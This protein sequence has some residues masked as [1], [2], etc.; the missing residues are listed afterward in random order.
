MAYNRLDTAELKDKLDRVQKDIETR[1]QRL[2]K[3]AT[4]EVITR[5][6]FAGNVE[7]LVQNNE[8]RWIVREVTETALALLRKEQKTITNELRRREQPAI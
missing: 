5:L 1:E 3:W 8:G 6:D 2:A 7:H 4:Q